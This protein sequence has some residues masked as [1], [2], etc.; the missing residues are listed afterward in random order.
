MTFGAV[1][2]RFAFL[3]FQIRAVESEKLPIAGFFA[4]T[5]F[6]FDHRNDGFGRKAFR[7]AVFLADDDRARRKLRIFFFDLRFRQIVC[8]NDAE[9][10][11]AVCR[12]FRI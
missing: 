7:T 12:V 2:F 11:S 10:K 5:F 4:E 3:H 9:R 6:A 8:V 1:A